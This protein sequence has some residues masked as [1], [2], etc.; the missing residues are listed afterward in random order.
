ML[1]TCGFPLSCDI[2]MDN[3]HYLAGICLFVVK[4]PY[5]QIMRVSVDIG[6]HI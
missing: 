1:D 3:I 5:R 4:L 6:K 2:I